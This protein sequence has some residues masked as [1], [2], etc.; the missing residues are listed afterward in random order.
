MLVL[1]NIMQTIISIPFHINHP[2]T[3]TRRCLFYKML[4]SPDLSNTKKKTVF[5]T[6]ACLCLDFH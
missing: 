5:D 3:R 4:G 2:L 1:T 6:K